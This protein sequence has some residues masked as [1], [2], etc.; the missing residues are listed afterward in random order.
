MRFIYLLAI[1]RL[2]YAAKYAVPL[3]ARMLGEIAAHDTSEVTDTPTNT[4]LAAEAYSSPSTV[5]VEEVDITLL[6]RNAN[7]EE[8]FED[9][10]SEESFQ[11]AI[12]PIKSRPV[13]RAQEIP[14]L[15][16]TD[17]AMSIS[18]VGST[19]YNITDGML[20]DGNGNLYSTNPGVPYM[21]FQAS[22]TPGNITTDFSAAADGSLLWQN[23][24]F[25]HGAASWC[26]TSN[27]TV[28]AVF[29]SSAQLP[30]CTFVNLRV[31]GMSVCSA[32]NF[33]GPA[34]PG[35][36]PGFN[37]SAGPSGPSGPSGPTGARGPSGPQGFNGSTGPSGPSGPSGPTGATGAS[38]PTGATGPS[39][40]S[41]PQGFNG[42]TGP[43]GPSGPTGAIG[44]T[45]PSGPSGPSGPQGFN[46]STGPSGPSGPSGPTGATGASGP[47]GA[48]GPSGPT[49]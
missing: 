3:D 46:G 10:S 32:N 7:S 47:T 1:A 44:A 6:T 26:V 43:S 18:C 2:G 21:V 4:S 40:P 31:V 25:S 37:G 11:L 22:S 34:G 9:Y 14:G 39:G 5:T 42:S 20:Y 38:G 36:P 16:G 17:G 12:S 29:N 35:G 15:L 33:T 8:E 28:L 48:T 49:G 27:N 30:T 41:G 23:A 24:Q 19:V 13:R 45:G